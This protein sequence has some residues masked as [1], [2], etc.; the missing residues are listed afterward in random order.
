MVRS[1]CL[2]SSRK[3]PNSEY[4]VPR[5]LSGVLIISQASETGMAEVIPLGPFGELYLSNQLGLEPAAF[6]HNFVSYRFATP[7]VLRLGE[8]R[9]RANV[10][11]QPFKMPGHAAPQGRS[12]A[13]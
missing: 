8:I 10:R 3:S 11:F 5:Y 12:E 1:A 13:I 2:C 6:S 7:R 4:L 9:E